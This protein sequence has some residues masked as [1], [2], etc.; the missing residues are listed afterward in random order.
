MASIVVSGKK[1]E[2]AEQKIRDLELKLA[3]SEKEASML[4][5]D[6][7]SL[8]AEV[9]KL[10][11]ENQDLQKELDNVL[12]SVGRKDIEKAADEMVGKA[13]NKVGDY[14]SSLTK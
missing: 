10:K 9:E 2:E 5:E 3:A 6:K 14:L 13:K 4:K 12:V 1:Y 11:T 8:T 7:T